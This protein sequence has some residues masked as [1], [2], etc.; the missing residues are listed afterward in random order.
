M[1]AIADQVAEAA[2]QAALA[3]EEFG[4]HG[5]VEIRDDGLVVSHAP[6]PLPEADK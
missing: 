4:E 6:S 1:S 3:A 5:G 2:L